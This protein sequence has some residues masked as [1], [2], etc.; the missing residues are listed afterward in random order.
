MNFLGACS[1]IK[2]TRSQQ[3][4][5]TASCTRPCCRYSKVLISSTVDLPDVVKWRTFGNKGEVQLLFGLLAGSIQEVPK[6][7]SVVKA[8]QDR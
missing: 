4:Y 5:L 8:Q 3:L 7:G 2:W 6:L 1:D